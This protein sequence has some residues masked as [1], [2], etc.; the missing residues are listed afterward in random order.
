MDEQKPESK[1]E[2]LNKSL[3]EGLTEKCDIEVKESLLAMQVRFLKGDHNW[4]LQ[5]IGVGDNIE[6]IL[7]STKPVKSVSFYYYNPKYDKP[8]RKTPSP[9]QSKLEAKTE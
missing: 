9:P 5:R 1:I 8:H 4:V 3:S 7:L 6:H 2:L